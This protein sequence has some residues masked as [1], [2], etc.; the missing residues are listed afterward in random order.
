MAEILEIPGDLEVHVCRL[1]A[2]VEILVLIRGEKES[3]DKAEQMFVAI[4]NLEHLMQGFVGEFNKLLEASLKG[5]SSDH[6][7]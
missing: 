1:K 4:E 6:P 3:R 7:S 2:M 5:R